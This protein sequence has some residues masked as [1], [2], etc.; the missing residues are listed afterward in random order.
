M[1]NCQWLITSVKIQRKK[2]QAQVH[3]IGFIE[4]AEYEFDPEICIEF[5]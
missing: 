1:V 5:V 2:K 3:R 4:K